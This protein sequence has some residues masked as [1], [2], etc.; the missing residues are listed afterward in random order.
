MSLGSHKKK[1]KSSNDS[2]GDDWSAATFAT[3]SPLTYKEAFKRHRPPHP[4]F[5]ISLVPCEIPKT[6]NTNEGMNHDEET[7]ADSRDVVAS[8][9]IPND[10]IRILQRSSSFQRLKIKMETLTMQAFQ[11]RNQF[12][13]KV[14]DHDSLTTH[15]DKPDPQCE[16][17]SDGSIQNEKQEQLSCNNVVTQKPLLNQLSMNTDKQDDL[18]ESY[19]EKTNGCVTSDTQLQ[20]RLLMESMSTQLQN[21]TQKAKKNLKPFSSSPSNGPN[22]PD[23]TAGFLNV[24]RKEMQATRTKMPGGHDELLLFLGDELEAST[25]G[26]TRIIYDF[27]DDVDPGKIVTSRRRG[28]ATIQEGGAVEEIL[29]SIEMGYEASLIGC[30]MAQ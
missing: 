14:D 28:M 5:R 26:R 15:G 23:E 2:D 7:I 21:M 24:L 1:K 6:S 9:E 12:H 29:E 11:R 13:R 30:G 18:L 20:S 3:E 22:L 4:K 27:E 19:G 17:S 10:E 8:Q 16:K 25:C